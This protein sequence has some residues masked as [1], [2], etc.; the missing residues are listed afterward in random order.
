VGEMV[1]V[2]KERMKV[3][4][5]MKKPLLEEEYGGAL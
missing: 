5:D 3:D 1:K 2:Q 4:A